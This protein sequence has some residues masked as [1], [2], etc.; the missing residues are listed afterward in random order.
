MKKVFLESHHLRNPYFGFGQF[1][2]HLIRALSQIPQDRIRFI[3]HGGEA[4]ELGKS[5]NLGIKRYFS[6]R[7]YPL[8]RIRSRYDLWHALNQNTR[9]EPYARTPYLLTVHNITHIKDPRNYTEQAVHQ[10]F[11]EK[12]N[13][14]DA[15]TYISQYAR[16][17]THRFF[18]VPSVP[19]KV[20]YN[21]NPIE[22]ILSLNG[23]RPVYLPERPFL[24]SIGEFT[25]RKNFGALI[26]MMPL[27]PHL[28]LIIAGKNTT[29]EAAELRE[30]TR[31]LGLEQRVHF[32][33]K[34]SELE[35]QYLFQN[36]KAFVFPS[37]REGFGLPVIEAMKFEKP[38]F[39]SNN[40]SLPEVGGSAAFLWDNYE[41]EEM[42]RVFR[43]GMKTYSEN[44]P[45][46]RKK[47][48]ERGDYFSWSRAA[49]QYLEVYESLLY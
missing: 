6:F 3:I 26:R 17:S 49:A 8:L 29:G 45:T 20:I 21:G 1:N 33:G 41:P 35:K 27:L 36:C 23:F 16:D 15:I 13:R 31:E 14:S 7:R 38:V 2:L 24:F 43:E 28:D 4:A 32:P 30:L 39:I 10:R 25:P 19:E 44:E 46:Y 37:L 22:Q 5:N 18:K 47:L 40:T 11:Q 42:S 34:V 9:I 12:L 48:R